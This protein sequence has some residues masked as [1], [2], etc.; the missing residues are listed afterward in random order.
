MYSSG[1]EYLLTH[2]VQV[3]GIAAHRLRGY[4]ALV[5][6]GVS[7]LGPLDLQGPLVDVPMVGGLETLIRRVGVGAHGEDVQVTMSYP[8]NLQKEAPLIRFSKDFK[9]PLIV[10]RLGPLGAAE[11][12]KFMQLTD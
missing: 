9:E 10:V 11:T 5:D 3:D 2:D 1:A 12:A 8:G 7:L 4:L 6:P